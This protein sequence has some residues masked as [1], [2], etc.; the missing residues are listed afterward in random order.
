MTN[1]VNYDAVAPAYDRRYE[2]NR[3]DGVTAVLQRFIYPAACAG[4]PAGA[5]AAEV[6]CGTGHWLAEIRDRVRTAAGLDLSA[7]MLHRARTTAPSARLVRGRAESLPWVKE[8]FDRLFCINALHHFADADAFMGEAYQVL[9]PGGAIM[10]V[11]LDPH[12]RL[13]RW[14]IYDYF[15]S[16]V[17]ADLARYLP[18]ES[19]RA[20]LASRGVRGRG[21]R[22]RAAHSCRDPVRDRSRTRRSRP[23]R[24]VS[25]DGDKRS[26][27]RGRV[28]ETHRRAADF[29][30]PISACTPPSRP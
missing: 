18:S 21:D 13:D 23:P 4:E 24:D 28:A 26:R 30:T 10:T 17:S 3:Y 1:P 14:W 7:G 11:G 5:D 8:S 16:A 25:V 12:T 27:V 20:R 19:I 29:S 9:R 6:G 15:P 2:R 22:G